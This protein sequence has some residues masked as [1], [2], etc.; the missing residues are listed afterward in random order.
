MLGRKTGWPF[1]VGMGWDERAAQ[2]QSSLGL[3]W[4][5]RQTLSFSLNK[6]QLTSFSFLAFMHCVR[7]MCVS[8]CQAKPSNSSW[9]RHRPLSQNKQP[10]Q[11][12]QQQQQQH[13]IS[14]D[15]DPRF[16]LCT[17]SAL[18][19]VFLSPCIS[20]SSSLDCV[21]GKCKLWLPW[22]AYCMPRYTMRYTMVYPYTI[23]DI[24][25]STP[26]FHFLLA[27]CNWW[28]FICAQMISRSVSR[29]L[30]IQNVSGNGILSSFVSG[31]SANCLII[32]W[33]V[34]IQVLV[35]YGLLDKSR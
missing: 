34:K 15:D 32:G 25:L 29:V 30:L 13:G 28:G 21:L 17:E 27:F 16:K 35:I 11:L 1:L 33:H 24:C 14:S 22:S 19:E 10:T 26:I 7:L 5:F 12:Q 6:R 31:D 9:H 20:L 23:F 4:R 18:I 2:S 8:V 3:E